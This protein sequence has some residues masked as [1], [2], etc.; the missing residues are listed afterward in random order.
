MRAVGATIAEGSTSMKLYDIVMRVRELAEW[1][2]ATF[3]GD[4]EKELSGAAPLE[5]AGGS[6]AAFVGNRKAAAQAASSGAGCLIVP[7]EWAS[8]SYRTAIRPPEPR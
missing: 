4:G 1:L 7:L 6:E 5:T 8:P 3:E 2:G